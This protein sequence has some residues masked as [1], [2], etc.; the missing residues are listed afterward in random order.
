MREEAQVKAAV[1]GA[2]HALG[3]IDV[4]VNAAGVAGGGPAHLC[5]L[6]EWRR[7]LDI[8]LTGTFLV[9]QARAARRC[10]RSSAAAS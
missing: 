2:L 3:G 1:E 6:A 9:T 8:N 5:D 4:V 7:V 10:W